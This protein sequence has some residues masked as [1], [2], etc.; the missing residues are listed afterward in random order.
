VV[1]ES[2]HNVYFE[3]AT[4]YNDAVSEFLAKLGLMPRLR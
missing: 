1:H 3:T 4:E 2:P